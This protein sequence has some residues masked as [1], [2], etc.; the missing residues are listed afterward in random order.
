MGKLNPTYYAFFDDN[1]LY[2]IQ[3]AHSG[4]TEAQNE[5]HKRI[6]QETAYL[7]GQVLFNQI[8]SGTTVA[9]GLFN[10][11]TL[12]QK[13]NLYTTD[14]FIG[15]ALLQSQE[16]NVAPAWKVIA[17]QGNISSSVPTFT[18]IL[19][20]GT[21]SRNRMEAGITQINIDANYALVAQGSEVRASFENLRNVQDTSRLFADDTVVRLEQR[22]A[23]IY[24]E[25]LNTELLVDNFDVEVFEVPTGEDAEL[26]RLYFKNKVPQV[27]DGMLVH[28]A[29]V[30]NTQELDKDSVEYYFSIDRD[31][32]IDPKIAC[33]YI[34]QFNTEDYL[35]DLDF[36]CE[37]IEVKT[38]TL[39]STAELRSQKYVQTNL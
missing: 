2:D 35:I 16:Q 34:N 30:E 4:A 14:A 11:A 28:S 38:S 25:E 23:L 12:I 13:D 39:I 37:D 3:Y 32:Q 17:M 10:E 24:V 18:G 29:P 21:T 22:D 27:V 36:D 15:D 20:S 8:L 26:R 1:V 9:G 7:E 33:K 5:T 31:Y 19:S 6:K